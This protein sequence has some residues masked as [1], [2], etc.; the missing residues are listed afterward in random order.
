METLGYPPARETVVN[1]FLAYASRLYRRPAHLAVN[2]EGLYLQGTPANGG[3]G[4][5]ALPVEGDR[6]IVTLTGRGGTQ[7]RGQVVVQAHQGHARVEGR[8]IR[9]ERRDGEPGG[10]DRGHVALEL[11]LGEAGDDLRPKEH[12]QT[13]DGRIRHARADQVE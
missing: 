5:L 13:V 9:Q 7:Q 3:R 1:S 12:V 2:G 8:V 11:D 4:G 6:L 10:V